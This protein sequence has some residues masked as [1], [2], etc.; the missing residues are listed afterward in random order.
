M[1]YIFFLECAKIPG[2]V[3]F[4]S[5]I[6]EK[7]YVPTNLYLYCGRGL[8]TLCFYQQTPQNCWGLVRINVR[9][10]YFL[11]LPSASQASESINL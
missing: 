4:L 11:R 5:F 6:M 2:H 3:L 1:I 10:D 9:A 7:Y 8:L